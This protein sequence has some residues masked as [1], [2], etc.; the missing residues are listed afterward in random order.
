MLQD[1][2]A[3]GSLF[4]LSKEPAKFAMAKLPGQSPTACAPTGGRSPAKSL[5]VAALYR[6]GG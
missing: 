4:N 6:T 2:G 1:P 3:S 5:A